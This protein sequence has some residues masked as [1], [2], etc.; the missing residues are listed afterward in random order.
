MKIGEKCKTCGHK[1][2]SVR[3][4]VQNDSLHLWLDKKSN[5]CNEAGFTMQQIIKETI[6]L[7]MTPKI[8]KEFWRAVQ[9]SMFHKKSTTQLSKTGEIDEVAE[10]LNRFFAKE[11]FFLDGIP[12]PSQAELEKID[13][14][15][16]K[17]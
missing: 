11:P 2:E 1:K 6:E 3:T 5:Q 13:E 7:E 8:M 4:K 16:I 15:F 14:T 17:N 9:K 12:F 10:H